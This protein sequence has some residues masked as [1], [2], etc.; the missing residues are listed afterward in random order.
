[1]L[2]Q[3]GLEFDIETVEQTQLASRV[4]DEHSQRKEQVERNRAQT[5]QGVGLEVSRW[6]PNTAPSVICETDS[7]GNL[8]VQDLLQ[9]PDPTGA[10]E[11]TEPKVQD[12]RIKQGEEHQHKIQQGPASVTLSLTK[13]RTKASPEEKPAIEDKE[14]SKTLCLFL[15]QK[16]A[17]Q[18]L[19]LTVRLN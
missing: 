11:K 6:N 2:C 17:G 16:I 3:G 18:L 9:Q 4:D 5:P 19:R 10:K 12:S 8:E 13:H 15:R 7:D 1:V 14:L